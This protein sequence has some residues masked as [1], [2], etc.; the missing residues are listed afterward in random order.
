MVMGFI[1]ASL[2]KP[3]TKPVAAKRGT[4]A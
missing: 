1:L 2:K 3:T 4:E